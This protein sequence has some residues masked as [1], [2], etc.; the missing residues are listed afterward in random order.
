M[1]NDPGPSLPPC[2]R[3][4]ISSLK[5]GIAKPPASQTTK[6]CPRR[7]GAAA[8]LGL[9][10]SAPQFPVER[11]EL[12]G[13]AGGSGWLLPAG[14][15]AGGAW[16]LSPQRGGSAAAPCGAGSPGSAVSWS[17][18]GTE[19]PSLPAAG[20]RGMAGKGRVPAA[21]RTPG[22]CDGRKTPQPFSSCFWPL[23]VGL[24]D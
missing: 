21:P 13:A 4:F 7:E 14:E 24:W 15:Q 6:W 20:G 1:E 5:H 11:A 3:I 18:E 19:R 10:G 17:A 23:R 12:A 9:R 22:A 2:E 8:M 16:R